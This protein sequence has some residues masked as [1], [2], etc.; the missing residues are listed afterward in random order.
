MKESQ[1]KVMMNITDANAANYNRRNET[2]SA[3]AG[4]RRLDSYIRNF[5]QIVNVTASWRPFWANEFRK[6]I[7]GKRVLEIGAGDFMTSF[8]MAKFGADVV[9]NE[10]S[11]SHR[12]YAF[13][14]AKITKTSNIQFQFG[15]FLELDF[16]SYLNYFDFIVGKGVIHHLTNSQEE[17]VYKKCVKLLNIKGIC[18]FS[19][20]KIEF[21]TLQFVIPVK[22][23]PSMLNVGKFRKWKAM[24]IHPDRDNSSHHYKKVCRKYFHKVEIIPFGCFDRFE[25]LFSLGNEPF[26]R[27]AYKLDHIVPKA[28]IETF[29]RTQLIMCYK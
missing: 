23:R 4:R 25:R 10:L 21:P 24:D 9:A 7:K 12:E 27:F 11:D 6:N 14:L 1:E 19:E 17:L 8:M 22:G 5:N 28:I 2:L 15:D 26:R 20:S 13:N 16:D 29:G 3:E 18:R